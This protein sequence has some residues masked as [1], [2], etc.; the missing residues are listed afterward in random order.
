MVRETPKY[1]AHV[2]FI[3]GFVGTSL[4]EKYL[5][6]IVKGK[7]SFDIIR[8]YMSSGREKN[9]QERVA[10]YNQEFSHNNLN[11][12]ANVIDKPNRLLHMK[13]YFWFNDKK[14]II[15]SFTGSRNFS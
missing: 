13:P 4:V 9:E 10:K 3:N 7:F 12:Q 8:S 14:E 11:N 6:E 1:N 15:P 2:V 5:F